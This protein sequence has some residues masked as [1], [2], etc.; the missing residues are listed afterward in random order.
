[1]QLLHDEMHRYS[2][3]RFKMWILLT[4]GLLLA[5]YLA[6]IVVTIN[7]FLGLS[8]Y[9]RSGLDSLIESYFGDFRF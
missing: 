2:Q 9:T 4:I 6:S 5:F 7:R 8:F 3:N 1:M